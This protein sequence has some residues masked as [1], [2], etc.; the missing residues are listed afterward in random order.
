MGSRPSSFLRYSSTAQYAQYSVLE[1]LGS[2][3]RQYH[4]CGT[5]YFDLLAAAATVDVEYYYWVSFDGGGSHQ[6]I[7]AMA[8]QLPIAPSDSV[9]A[10][11]RRS[12]RKAGKPAGSVARVQDVERLPSRPCHTMFLSVAATNGGF[13]VFAKAC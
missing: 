13:A 9:G 11:A 12:G 4:S 3:R 10:A 1:I 7:K 8:P 5:Q 2:T 6:E